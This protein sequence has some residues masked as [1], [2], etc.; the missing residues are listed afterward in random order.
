MKAKNFLKRVFK[1]MLYPGI[2]I[3][4]KLVYV[5]D[6]RLGPKED[7]AKVTSIL[8]WCREHDSKRFY[9]TAFYRRRELWSLVSDLKKNE[10][11]ESMKIYKEWKNLPVQITYYNGWE[12]KKISDR[13]YCNNKERYLIIN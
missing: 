1:I 9:K 5:D 7:S 8:D 11:E 3:Y 2:I 10:W 4:T 12:I 6:V 13:Y